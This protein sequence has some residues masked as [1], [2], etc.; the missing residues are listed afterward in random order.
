MENWFKTSEE[1]LHRN[2]HHNQSHQFHGDF[3]PGFAQQPADFPG[4]QQY[5]VGQA[6]GDNNGEDKDNLERQLGAV[7]HQ[8]NRVR[9]CPGPR[10][11][12]DSQRCNGDVIHIFFNHFLIHFYL[13]DSGLQQV[14]A[15]DEKDDPADNPEPVNR[16]AKKPE[17][18]LSAESKKQ[19]G[20]KCSEYR[21]EGSFPSLFIRQVG[22]HGHKNRHHTQR[23]DDGEEGGEVKDCDGK[24]FVVHGV[25]KL[26][27]PPHLNGCSR[28][29]FFSG[30]NFMI[31]NFQDLFFHQ[32]CVAFNFSAFCNH[33]SNKCFIIQ[34]GSIDFYIQKCTHYG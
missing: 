27:N 30:V 15:H 5:D 17:H 12:G 34:S 22:G 1:K 3:V 13:A 16:Y 20:D 24:K 2:Y 32:L 21:L 8:N 4:A 26:N 10:N 28:L 14:E 23:I 19:Q 31:D 25:G 33:G 7:F 18:Q 9:N 6:K 11:D 29:L